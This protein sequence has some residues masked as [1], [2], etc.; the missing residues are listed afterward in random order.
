MLTVRYPDGTAVQFNTAAR[1]QFDATHMMLL[2]ERNE[3][4]AVIPY[5]CAVEAATPCRISN[6]IKEPRAMLQWVIEHARELPV[7]QLAQL[8]SLLHDFNATTRRWKQS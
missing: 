5:S 2:N 8:K 4:V 1:V 3:W 7:S 6:P